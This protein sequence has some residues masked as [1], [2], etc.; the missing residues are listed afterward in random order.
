MRKIIDVNNI[1]VLIQNSQPE[2]RIDFVFIT[3]SMVI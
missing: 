1:F 3:I 2:V